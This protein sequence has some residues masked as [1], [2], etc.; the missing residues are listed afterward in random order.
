[1]SDLPEQIGVMV[2][3]DGSG[4][5]F[6]SLLNH[7]R[8]TGAQDVGD[9]RIIL[10]NKGTKEGRPIAAI[11]FTAVLEGTPVTVQ[12]VTTLRMLKRA[13]EII[14]AHHPDL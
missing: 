3:A 7:C 4:R 13:L 1:M 11:T 6:D 12:T 2:D 10:K 9:L 5:L 14:N 8:A